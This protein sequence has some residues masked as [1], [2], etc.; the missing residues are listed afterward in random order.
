[1]TRSS[2]VSGSSTRATWTSCDAAWRT[3]HRSGCEEGCWGELVD[4]DMLAAAG[5]GLCLESCP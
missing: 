2:T 3:S 5:E 4:G 1:M